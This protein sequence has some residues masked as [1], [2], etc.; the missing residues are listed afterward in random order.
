MQLTPGTAFSSDALQAQLTRPS[1]C[2]VLAYDDGVNPTTVFF[3]D[4]DSGRVYA[5]YPAN[6]SLAVRTW[7]RTVCPGDFAPCFIPPSFLAFLPPFSACLPDE[8]LPASR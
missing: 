2:A 8:C 5:Y 7:V 6:Q 3:S 4:Y 1:S